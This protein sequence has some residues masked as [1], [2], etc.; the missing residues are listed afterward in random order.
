VL[1]HEHRVEGDMFAGIIASGSKLGITSGRNLSDS[2]VD[3][4]EVETS[5]RCLSERG[6]FGAGNLS[7]GIAEYR[8]ALGT[9]GSLGKGLNSLMSGS[10]FRKA[11][12]V[13]DLYLLYRYGIKPVL[14]DIQGVIDG[15]EEVVME[16]RETTRA[17]GKLSAASESTFQKYHDNIRTDYRL[18]IIDTVIVR[19]MS[20]DE[21]ERTRL[22]NIGLNLKGILSLPWELTTLSF[23]ADWMVNFGDYIG[24][25]LPSLGYNQLGS[26]L[27]TE[28]KVENVWTCLGSFEA[29]AYSVLRPVSGSLYASE[30]EKIR[31]PLRTP[32]LVIK[33]DFRLTTA[34]RVGDA[35]SLAGSRLLNKIDSFWRRR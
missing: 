15:L 35:F 6:R 25:L 18:Q 13:S 4:L 26:C 16:R 17:S 32:S 31:G 8:E 12:G 27:V 19:A 14:S 3:S 24:V 33:A 9:F 29:A 10:V 34:T 23:V 20:L 7:E 5:T 22:N 1:K 30:T 2:D 11:K 21:V 28:R